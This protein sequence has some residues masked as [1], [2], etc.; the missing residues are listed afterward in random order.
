MAAED[1]F[2]DFNSAFPSSKASSASEIKLTSSNGGEFIGSFCENGA[3]VESLSAPSVG[4]YSLPGGGDQLPGGFSFDAFAAVPEHDSRGGGTFADFGAFNVADVAIPPPLSVELGGFMFD[5]PPLPEELNDLTP[6][7]SSAAA[8]TRGSDAASYDGTSA[9]SVAPDAYNFVPHMIPTL[10]LPA[11]SDSTISA[12]HQPVN[13]INVDNP[14]TSSGN[15]IP[16]S[17][18]DCR[19]SFLEQTVTGVAGKPLD[20]L[21]PATTIES[22]MSD[23]ESDFGDFESSIGP[24]MLSITQPSSESV[25]LD[26]EGIDMSLFSDILT[27]PGQ[28]EP[29]AEA[30]AGQGVPGGFPGEAVAEFGDFSRVVADM[31][32]VASFGSATTPQASVAHEQRGHV[33]AASAEEANPGSGRGLQEES[34]LDFGAFQQPDT[35]GSG[36]LGGLG[37]PHNINAGGA[38]EPGFGEDGGKLDADEFGDFSVVAAV[39]SG[40]ATGVIH[41]LGSFEPFASSNPGAGE[42]TGSF[43]AFGDF[44]NFQSSTEGAVGTTGSTGFG[45]F[46]AASSEVKSGA[47]QLEGDSDFG[48]FEAF[49]VVPSSG[50]VTGNVFGEFSDSTGSS[51]PLNVSQFPSMPALPSSIQSTVA[52]KVTPST[53]PV[54]NFI[55]GCR[56][57]HAWLIC[58]YVLIIMLF[59]LS[60]PP[61]LLLTLSLPPSL[62]LSL[63]SSLPHSSR[64]LLML[65]SFASLWRAMTL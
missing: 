61:T 58:L 41:S 65:L 47:D 5:I 18:S 21:V 34:A 33:L 10:Q 32:G 57:G 22:V 38:P 64:H 44:S 52:V 9:G 16:S 63:P 60:L 20:A 2:G 35:T 31:V 48:A 56:K 12:I 53:N 59:W 42:G 54:C 17:L 55:C 11:E 50:G 45:S 15:H 24:S 27:S 8:G 26:Q 6:V 51:R 1:D 36:V 46:E 19:N 29:E 37:R 49:S 23:G 4:P 14:P 7:S 25:G 28:P 39:S 30:V 40:G 13:S 3:R 62:P 43:E